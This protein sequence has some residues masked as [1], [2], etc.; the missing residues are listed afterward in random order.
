M[1]D[2]PIARK[3]ILERFAFRSID[4]AR[5]KGENMLRETILALVT[6]TLISG[7]FATGA[8]AFAG[9]FGAAVGGYPAS[10]GSDYTEGGRNC[11]LVAKRVMT[12]HGWRTRG[13][14]VCH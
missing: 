14:R 10:F 1:A 5:Q 8:V 3:Q 12:R 11:R 13:V 9:G 6:A 7:G 4:L 2:S